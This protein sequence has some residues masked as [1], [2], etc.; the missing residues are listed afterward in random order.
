MIPEAYSLLACL[1]AG[2]SDLKSARLIRH[3]FMLQHCSSSGPV[4][5][6]HPVSAL[7]KSKFLGVVANAATA[8]VARA[9]NPARCRRALS[10]PSVWVTPTQRLHAHRDRML[11]QS[12]SLA[13]PCSLTAFSQQSSENETSD[14]QSFPQCYDLPVFTHENQSS[15]LIEWLYPLG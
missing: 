4:F 10:T 9:G 2:T 15:S 3:L 14:P 12:M 7:K 1:A 5:C 8:S 13:L 11:I 6:C